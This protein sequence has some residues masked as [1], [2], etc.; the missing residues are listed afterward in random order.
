VPEAT[1]RK[2]MERFRKHMRAR[3]ARYSGL[4]GAVLAIVLLLWARGRDEHV[5]SPR[6]SYVAPPPETPAEH[7][8]RLRR[9]A[10]T[11]CD[12]SDF[13]TCRARL[14][15]ARA[16]DP[17]GEATPEVRQLR[18]VVRKATGDAGP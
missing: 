9:D 5:S 8:T 1:V 6:P 13:V 17:D 7:A 2:R 3:W 4:G 10:K 18:D 11:A 16:L 14:D 12:A 15:D